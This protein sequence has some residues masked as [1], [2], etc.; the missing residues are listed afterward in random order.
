MSTFQP[1]YDTWSPSA[2]GFPVAEEYV[3][4]HRKP[5]APRRWAFFRFFYVGRHRGR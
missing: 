4:R 3:G 2:A 5:D 1:T